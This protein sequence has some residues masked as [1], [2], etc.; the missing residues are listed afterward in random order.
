[1]SDI[2]NKISEITKSLTKASSSLVKT[3]KLS[4]NIS[5]AED[6]LKNLYIELGKKVHEIYAYG[7][8][9]G[10]FF[11]EKY[12]EILECEKKIANLRATLETAKGTKACFNCKS[13]VS[14]DA[15]FCT[16]CGTDLTK[17]QD[18]PNINSVS[19][20]PEKLENKIICQLC[21][22]END[23]DSKFCISCGRQVIK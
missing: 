14:R 18:G 11:D 8:S 9:L 3:T 2:R 7:G 1:M 17:V 23:A 4:L 10:K 5:S 19:Q 22:F 6:E 15:L 20:I 12:L 16:K 21:N 13:I